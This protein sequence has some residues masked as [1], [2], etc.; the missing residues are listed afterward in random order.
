ME[1]VVSLFFS[2]IE[3]SFVGIALLCIINTIFVCFHLVFLHLS[4]QELEC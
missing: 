3:I 1:T 4:I 2:P